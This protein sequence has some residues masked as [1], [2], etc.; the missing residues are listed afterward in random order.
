[1]ALQFLIYVYQLV[2]SIFNWK[3]TDISLQNLCQVSGKI[4]FSNNSYISFLFNIS[5]AKTCFL[6]GFPPPPPLV[7]L[8][9]ADHES[10]TNTATL[11][12]LHLKK[13]EIKLKNV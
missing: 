1:V 6:D 8:I 5:K 10:P 2:F 11:I 13:E 4:L 9:L 3:N 12:S 7:K